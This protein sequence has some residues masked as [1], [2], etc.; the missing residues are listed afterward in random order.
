MDKNNRL[1]LKNYFCERKNFLD[2]ETSFEHD[3]NIEQNL[4]SLYDYIYRLNLDK[5]LDI[6]VLRKIKREVANIIRKLKYKRKINYNKVILALMEF[7]KIL[8]NF[9][10]KKIIKKN[11]RYFKKFWGIY[12]QNILLYKS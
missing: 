1:Y 6:K 10:K 12:N 9:D 4:N 2:F 11:T 3:F 5:K 7:N 8:E